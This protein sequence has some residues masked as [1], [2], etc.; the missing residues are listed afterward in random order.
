MEIEKSTVSVCTVLY[1]ELRC[2]SRGHIVKS[3]KVLKK[4]KKFKMLS[5]NTELSVDA[6]NSIR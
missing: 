5:D 4:N 6:Q 3:E 1:S 2:W